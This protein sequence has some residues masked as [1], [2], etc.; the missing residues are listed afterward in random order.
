MYYDEDEFCFTGS[1]PT[2][3]DEGGR[4]VTSAE[5]VFVSPGS[6]INATTW[7]PDITSAYFA[8][9]T[10]CVEIVDSRSSETCDSDID[11]ALIGTNTVGS[12]WKSTEDFANIKGTTT[13]ECEP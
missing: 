13:L 1:W 6:N 11:Y 12:T 2:T 3:A 4:T 5:A 7:T 8:V 10:Y 9:G